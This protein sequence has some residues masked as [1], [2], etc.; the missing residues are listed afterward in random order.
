M[1]RYEEALKDFD[2]AIELNPKLDWAIARRGYTYLM[3]KRYNEALEN[4][5]CAINLKPDDDW[6]LYSRALAYQALNQVDKARVDLNNATK[7]AQQN[8]QKDATDWRN[9]FN[10][11][12]HYLIGG[13][14]ELSQR[15]YQY[16]LSSHAPLEHIRGAI[17]DLED[18]SS[19]FP[20][21]IE[22]QSMRKFLQSSL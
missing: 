16:A 21:Y 9:T 12:L 14:V 3:L 7:L 13:N 10:L 11:A 20:E 22:A 17:R 1:E 19:I 18:F 8:Y 2:R 5:N 4:F 15:L 6:G